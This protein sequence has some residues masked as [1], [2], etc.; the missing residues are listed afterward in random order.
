MP[1]PAPHGGQLQDLIK[2]DSSIKANLLEEIRGNE[3]KSLLLTERQL[4]DIELIL[5]GG[6]SPLKG[7]LNE[8]DY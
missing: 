6:F 5:N 4:C 1:I 7:F 2:R 3:Y 8:D